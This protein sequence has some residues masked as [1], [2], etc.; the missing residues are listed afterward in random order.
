[1]RFV[2]IRGIGLIGTIVLAIVL[3]SSSGEVNV[4]KKYSENL[5]RLWEE[6]QQQSRT[7]VRIEE[8]SAQDAAEFQGRTQ[9]TNTDIVVRVRAGFDREHT[10]Q[11]LAHELF[12]V[13]LTSEGFPTRYESGI[14]LENPARKRFIESIGPKL[15]SCFSDVVIDARMGER[16]FKPELLTQEMWNALRQIRP[17]QISETT[18]HDPIWR[19]YIAVS[20]FCF[21]FRC[22]KVSGA[23]LK[24]LYD[25][26]GLNVS[27]L[28]SRLQDEFRNVT[29]DDLA[30]PRRCFLATKQLRDLAGLTE[31]IRFVNPETGQLE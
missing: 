24:G 5:Q 26:L 25:Q 23:D 15:V 31:V 1:M 12:H 9:T 30:V 10:E 2:L 11:I 13:L 3:S 21:S 18:R 17:E 29:V 20:L 6:V 8:L 14:P 4:D 7:P 27:N 19:S 16:G 22:P 28:V